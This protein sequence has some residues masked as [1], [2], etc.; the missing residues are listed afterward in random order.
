MNREDFFVSREFL[1]VIQSHIFSQFKEARG[2]FFIIHIKCIVCSREPG[3][4]RLAMALI[5]I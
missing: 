3:V 5:I 4:E 1:E 2:E